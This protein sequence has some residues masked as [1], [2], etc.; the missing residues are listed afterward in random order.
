V[1]TADGGNGDGSDLD[2]E[3]SWLLARERGEPRPPPRPELAERYDRLIS[4]IGQLPTEPVPETVQARTLRAIEAADAA[5][6]AARRRRTLLV[7]A[8]CIASA[9]ALLLLVLRKPPRTAVAMAP[10][11]A[12]EIR[13]SGTVRGDIASVGDILTVRGNLEGPGELRIYLDEDRLVIRCPGDPGCR[14]ERA[15]RARAILAELALQM[16]GEYRSYLLVG[17]PVPPPTGRAS[18]DLAAATAAGIAV[19]TRVPLQVQ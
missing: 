4:L 3:L 8:A 14:E 12:V 18:D 6:V 16:P 19:T 1:S 5:A 2:E 15:G 11:L 7:A 10:S 9:A 13:R 17:A